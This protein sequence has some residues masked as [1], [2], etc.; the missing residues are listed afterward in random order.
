MTNRSLDE[1]NATVVQTLQD[2]RTIRKQSQRLLDFARQHKLHHFTVN[3]KNMAATADFV[4]D[5]M[6]DQYPTLAI[7]YHTRWRHF[8]AGG[9]N[10]MPDL[11]RIRP[12]I[13][14]QEQGRI[15]FE[16]V[17]ISVFL[18][19]GAGDQWRYFEEKSANY[20]SRSEGLGIA[21]L[22]LYLQGA[23]SAKADQP[24]RVDSKALL[25]LSKSDLIRGFQVREDNPLQGLEGRVA[26]LNRLGTTLANHPEY[27]GL[28][29]R[30]GNFYDYV[31]GLQQNQ[32]LLAQTLFQ[33][34]LNAFAD[35]W[36]KR[37]EYHGYPLGDVWKHSIL[38]SEIP[39]SDYIPF[40]KLSQW[41][42]YSL[43]EPL[44]QLGTN[45]TELNTLT[46]LAEYRN[47][48]LFL[49][50]GVLELKDETMR[51]Q[52]HDPASEIIVEWR[53]L[54]IALLDELAT[55]IRNRLNQSADEMPLAKILQG[56]TWEAG[57][58]I[59]R[60]KRANGAPPLQIIS[61]GTVF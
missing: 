2:L 3:D 5:V 40:H 36:P 45:I 22:S 15:L 31:D 59:A 30:L 11:S 35:V 24:F 44:E 53:G 61:D 10:R 28:E 12:G 48:G 57:R 52:P 46:G 60:E 9:I 51:N 56:G 18:D 1:E 16:L 29:G 20:F 58:R 8:E 42:S 43:V 50:M 13:T 27:F 17:I 14:Q 55:L 41:L 38:K 37:L 19:A 49:D 34:V 21:S 33:A 54:T 39:G 7:P 4:L 23:F 26:L 47:G 6:Q 25:A 32:S